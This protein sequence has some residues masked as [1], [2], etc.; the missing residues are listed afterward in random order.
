M[1]VSQELAQMD[2]LFI[3]FVTIVVVVVVAVLGAIFGGRS[4]VWRG[5]EDPDFVYRKIL[6]EISLMTRLSRQTE[7]E[8][9]AD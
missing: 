1:D 2:F 7:E 5:V 4:L 3:L 9:E 8:T 6:S